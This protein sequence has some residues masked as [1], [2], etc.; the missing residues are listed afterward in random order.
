MLRYALPARESSIFRG[1]WYK[2]N[3]MD[4]SII[5]GSFLTAFCIQ[6]KKRSVNYKT[7]P[8][9]LHKDT[10]MDGAVPFCFPFPGS[11]MGEK[12][13]RPPNGG[14]ALHFGYRPSPELGSQHSDPPRR[15]VPLSRRHPAPLRQRQSDPSLSDFRSRQQQ[16]G[17]R[18]HDDLGS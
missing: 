5:W 15:G 3:Q 14:R 18:R 11:A 4:R 17:V 16:E 9:L 12:K 6:D 10:W 7:N 8:V 1:R 13:A 2:Q